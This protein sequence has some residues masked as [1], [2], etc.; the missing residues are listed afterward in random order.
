MLR[1]SIFLAGS[2]LVARHELL[3]AA[4][5]RA[6]SQILKSEACPHP[7]GPFEPKAIQFTETSY[8]NPCVLRMVTAKPVSLMSVASTE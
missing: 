8:K 7:H 2:V 6:N 1:Q 5:R 4:W 3:P